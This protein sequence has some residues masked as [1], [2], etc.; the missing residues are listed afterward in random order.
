MSYHY[1]I[2]PEA[3]VQLD[4]MRLA[5]IRSLE[6][7]DPI[8]LNFK[9][10]NTIHPRRITNNKSSLLINWV[11]PDGTIDGIRCTEDTLFYT[12]TK[13]DTFYQ[14][15]ISRADDLIVGDLLQSNSYTNPKIFAIYKYPDIEDTMFIFDSPESDDMVVNNVRICIR[16]GGVQIL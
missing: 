7:I 12:V 1:G 5:R 14:P 9:T 16:T 10:F 3:V 11:Y 13:E 6:Y 2:A 4:D 15:L 8:V